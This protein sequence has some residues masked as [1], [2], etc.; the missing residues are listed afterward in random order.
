MTLSSNRI[1]LRHRSVW[2]SPTGIAA[3][4]VRL[5]WKESF[6][7]WRYSSSDTTSDSGNENGE[8]VNGTGDVSGGGTTR[9]GSD[10]EG[11]PVCPRC[12]EP[13]TDSF[14]VISELVSH[15]AH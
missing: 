5:K 8:S 14:N 9:G 15:C 2:A 4:T 3:P 11:K 13:F 10:H 7:L 6:R 1:D 12:G